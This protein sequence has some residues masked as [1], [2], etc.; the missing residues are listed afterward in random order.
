[1]EARGLLDR[2]LGDFGDH[3]EM[4]DKIGRNG[5]IVKFKDFENAIVKIQDNQHDRL[6][7]DEQAAVESLLLPEGAAGEDDAELQNFGR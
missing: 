4:A 1:M 7:E 6:T 2:L 5:S 3:A